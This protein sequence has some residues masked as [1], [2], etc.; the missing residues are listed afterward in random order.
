MECDKKAEFGNACEMSTSACACVIANE[1]KGKGELE[2]GA[3]KHT[4]HPRQTSPHFISLYARLTSCFVR[5]PVA[6]GD[7]GGQMNGEAARGMAGRN[8]MSVL[9]KKP[10]NINRPIA[11]PLGLFAYSRLRWLPSS[12]VCSS[13]PLGRQNA[14]H[15]SKYRNPQIRPE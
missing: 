7:D 2:E 13:S 15:R 12:G 14:W 1:A 11:Y 10:K 3:T 9:K 5:K 4:V 6:R 8:Q